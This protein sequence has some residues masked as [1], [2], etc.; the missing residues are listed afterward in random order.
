[1]DHKN[2]WLLAL[3]FSTVVL[4]ASSL[5][6]QHQGHG[7]HS[8]DLRLWEGSPAGKA[9]SEFNHHLAGVF[10]LLMGLSELGG[11]LATGFLVWSR[12]VLPLAMLGAGMYLL[13]WSDHEAW[14]IGS[15]SFSQTLLGGDF[16]ILQH[17]LYAVFLLGVGGIE[18]L[19]RS[20]MI[21]RSASGMPLP[22]FAILGGVLLFLHQHGDH[23]VAQKIAMNHMVMGTLAVAAG[24]CKLAGW[25][26][27]LGKTSAAK[28]R[29]SGW[30]LAWGGL[31][32]VIGVQLLFYTE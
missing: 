3:V 21:R 28:A 4:L 10:V 15:L 1:M 7:A 20:G 25:S 31:I 26:K 29:H 18:M 32:L 5:Q 9:Y 17:K 14:P 19:R 27:L 23:P 2:A 11:A 24:A 30:D 6:A 12:F 13:G 8:P 22:L 16:E